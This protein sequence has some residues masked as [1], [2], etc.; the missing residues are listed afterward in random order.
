MNKVAEKSIS[1][2]VFVLFTITSA[3]YNGS[4]IH[5]HSCQSTYTCQNFVCHLYHIFFSVSVSLYA[6]YVIVWELLEV[7][8]FW[9]KIKNLFLWCK[10]ETT[11]PVKSIV[12]M[13]QNHKPKI[14]CCFSV[15]TLQPE[16]PPC[17][18]AGFDCY[19]TVHMQDWD[20]SKLFTECE[21]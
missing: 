17:L 14:Y 3:S 8:A 10:C 9:L 11:M 2:S 18:L 19:C 12:C 6:V 15:Q 4:Y 13:T 7:L 16:N 5:F 1:V 21:M 20:V